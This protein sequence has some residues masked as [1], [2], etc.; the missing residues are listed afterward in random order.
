MQTRFAKHLVIAATLAGLSSCAVALADP[1]SGLVGHWTLRGD[2][3]DCSGQGNHGVNHGVKLDG[4]D[5]AD[6]PDAAR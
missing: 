6:T 1:G 3:R 5:G 2:C 4:G